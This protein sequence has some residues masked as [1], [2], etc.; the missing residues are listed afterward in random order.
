MEDIKLMVEVVS[1]IDIN[2][3]KSIDGKTGA[4]YAALNGKED[5]V[6][7]LLEN[8]ARQEDAAQGRLTKKYK[9]P[10]FLINA[11]KAGDLNDVKSIVEIVGEEV[12]GVKDGDGKTGAYLAAFHEKE[13]VVAYLLENGARTVSYTHLTL[14]TICS[15]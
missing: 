12:N 10:P 4:Y 3:A 6:A 7:Y 1:P 14:P 5:V 15:V 2:D 9:K 13:D 11:C 8:G